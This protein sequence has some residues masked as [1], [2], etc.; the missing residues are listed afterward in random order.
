MSV[1]VTP[2]DRFAATVP[3]LLFQKSAEEFINATPLPAFAV[4]ADGERILAVVRDRARHPP[5][6]TIEF[7]ANWIDELRAKLKD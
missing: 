3:R 7:V 4:T 5:P 2:G 6:A 1:T